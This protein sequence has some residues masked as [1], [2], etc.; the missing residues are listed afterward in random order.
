MPNYS[1]EMSNT[2]E[3]R[4]ELLEFYLEKIDPDTG[5]GEGAY[6]ETSDPYIDGIYTKPANT[7]TD[8]GDSTWQE[9]DY[10]HKVDNSEDSGLS[11][12]RPTTTAQKVLSLKPNVMRAWFKADP[13]Q[14]KRSFNQYCVRYTGKPDPNIE[15]SLQ[16]NTGW[17]N[18]SIKQD[19]EGVFTIKSGGTVSSSAIEY[20]AYKITGLTS[21]K[22]YYFNFKCNF[23]DG[24]TFGKDFTKG[25][26][27]VFNTTGTIDT[28]D[29][30]GDPDTFNE[31]TKY[32]SMRRT[33]AGN[34]ANFNFTATASTMYMCIVVADI[35]NGQTSSLTLSKMVISQTEKACVRDF[36]IFDLVS[37]DW[38]PYKPW[39]SGSGD[40]GGASNL[41]DLDDVNLDNLANGQTLYYDSATGQWVNGD[42][43]SLPIASANTLG[44][45]KVGDNLS[46][47]ENGVLSADATSIEE[48]NDIGDVEITNPSNGQTLVYDSEEEKWI[49]SDGG[50]SNLE[51]IDLNQSQYNALTP[52]EKAD[53]DKMYFI[54]D[55]NGDGTINNW[56]ISAL[57]Y[58]QLTPV[59]YE[60]LSSAQ[61]NDGTVYFVS[62]NATGVYGLK[63]IDITTAEYEQL[64]PEQKNN[65]VP[66]FVHD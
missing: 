64:T 36:Y 58:K 21:G 30:T 26:G 46:I 41:G 32:Y 5:E 10:V 25:L 13:P 2:N 53:L 52:A 14:V 17:L 38:L 22:K 8:S 11:Y 40:E 15:I 54:T 34:F 59:Q 50:S 7:E 1:A 9:V 44:G 63:V 62:D 55:G 42:S 3:V 56:T 20:C 60:A 47:D 48:L 37:N 45:I 66:Y 19:S 18:K 29:W 27:L 16:S 23:K 61:K 43:Y 35:Q 24:T 6:T 31:S 65:G 33:T 51:A 39:G 28:D 49:N 12:E 4:I 57:A